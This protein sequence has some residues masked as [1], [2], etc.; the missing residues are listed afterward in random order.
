MPDE[1]ISESGKLF[2]ESKRSGGSIIVDRRYQYRGSVFESEMRCLTDASSSGIGGSVSDHMRDGWLVELQLQVSMLGRILLRDEDGSAPAAYL[3][4]S[5]H[6]L[7]ASLIF[8]ECEEISAYLEIACKQYADSGLGSPAPVPAIARFTVKR[9]WVIDLLHDA[10]CSYGALMEI[11]IDSL[12]KG[13]SQRVE[14]LL[15]CVSSIIYLLDRWFVYVLNGEDVH[16]ESIQLEKIELLQ[17]IRGQHVRHWC[18]LLRRHLHN[19]SIARPMSTIDRLSIEVYTS[20]VK[21]LEQKI[22]HLVVY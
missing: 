3:G 8:N 5:M 16:Q 2:L 20:E 6:M 4:A 11:A 18:D 22:V 10:G 19:I 17:A 15:R 12:P 21:A 9:G 13:E 14:C 1:A 7:P